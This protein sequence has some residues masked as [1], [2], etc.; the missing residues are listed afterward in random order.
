MILRRVTVQNVRSYESGQIEL[1]EGIVA[2]WGD[3]GA[4]KSS[5][6]HAIEV[7]LFGFA[8]YDYGHLLRQGAKEASV[9]IVLDGD[10]SSLTLRRELTRTFSGGRE[11]APNQECVLVQDGH[12]MTYGVTQ[13]KRRVLELLGFP[14]SP[15]PR[16]HSEIWRWSVYVRQESMREILAEEGD[17]LEVIRKAHGLEEYRIARE[18]AKELAT[19]MRRRAEDFRR[20]AE[21]YLEEGRGVETLLAQAQ[22]IRESLSHS[23][24]KLTLL[25]AKGPPLDAKILEMRALREEE[26][27]LRV[28]IQ[29]SK[30]REV[31]QE[32]RVK[33]LQ[34]QVAQQDARLTALR[35]DQ[36]RFENERRALG[37]DESEVPSLTAVLDEAR[38]QREGVERS[39]TE[40]SHALVRKKD[41]DRSLSLFQEQMSSRRTLR[42]TREA[43]IERLAQELGPNPPLP[44]VSATREELEH[45]IEELH[46]EVRR[47]QKARA[48]AEQTEED[49]RSLLASGSCPR[50][51]QKVDPT[52][53][54][55]HLRE[56]KEN[57][58]TESGALA[59]LEERE[60]NLQEDLRRLA[61]HRE[62]LSGWK[63]KNQGL[64]E[65]RQE[66]SRLDAEMAQAE[67]QGKELEEKLSLL[68]SQIAGLKDG[69]QD[70]EA[71]RGREKAARESLEAAQARVDRRKSLEGSLRVA[72]EGLR[73]T[74][75]SRERLL[76]ES[77]RTAEELHGAQ[78]AR[79]TLETRQKELH[80]RLAS[81]QGVEEERQKLRNALEKLRV[82]IANLEKD[83]EFQETERKRK[84]AA[85][86]KN[87][88]AGAAAE[89]Q[90][91][92]V[93][94]LKKLGDAF[95]EIEKVRLER[96]RADF[97]AGFSRFYSLLVEDE[98]MSA[99]V[100]AEFRPFVVMGG[101]S[102][103]ATALSGGERT[104]L[105]LAYRLA[106]R[107][108]V[109]GAH[110]LRLETLILD[111]PTEGFSA[112]QVLKLSE[113][114]RELGV[115]QILLVSHEKNLA[116][117]ADHMISVEKQDGRSLILPGATEAAPPRA[118]PI[119]SL[120]P[121][122]TGQQ[123]LE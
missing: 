54:E 61:T 79:T 111:E 34:G 45:E 21:R 122:S 25:E 66:V 17:R 76:Q 26:S 118:P 4:G 99:T 91:R 57:L 18:N 44:P 64:A 42:K 11:V 6:L 114:L 96:I 86:Q 49:L 94:W 75:E 53:F 1:G 89:L 105:A 13:M 28:R 121:P 62:T 32:K 107:Q 8:D 113:L 35:A 5:L 24:E 84:E 47:H 97:L 120:T 95:G 67:H 98:L 46:K 41:L 12:R 58:Q 38:K 123:R 108:T 100:D 60:H 48:G 39:S 78:E 88:T 36:V 27:I 81:Y 43:E 23:K 52:S 103:P 109:V 87:R 20:D 119:T 82:D 92:R 10:G 106:L 22:A 19:E 33:D 69:A 83:L 9:E 15:N 2:L 110:R 3:I 80:P 93:E 102:I 71:A 7:A 74:E 51:G 90:L 68:V 50:C 14:E 55:G 16:R 59:H 115:R 56:A 29:E 72:A 40:L 73:L 65:K 77:A 117:I 104:A 116:S 70:L 37:G 30:E 101:A 112:D 85:L 63:A 31:Q